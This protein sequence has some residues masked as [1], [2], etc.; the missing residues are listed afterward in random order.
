MR[1]FSQ[2]LTDHPEYHPEDF[3]QQLL[4]DAASEA[5]Q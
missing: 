2:W 1:G 5:Q 3:V 4:R